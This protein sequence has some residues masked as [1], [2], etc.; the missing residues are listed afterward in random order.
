MDRGR[1][2]KEKT[3]VILHLAKS[4]NDGCSTDFKLVAKERRCIHI[5]NLM[6]T[7]KKVLLSTLQRTM[8]H[9]EDLQ[10]VQSHCQHCYFGPLHKSN[11]VRKSI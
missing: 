7:G 8:A 11:G 3:N 2:K 1:K 4:G 9:C 10:D 6:A 5:N